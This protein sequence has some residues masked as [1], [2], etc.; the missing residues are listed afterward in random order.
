MEAF[1]LKVMRNYGGA[2]NRNGESKVPC[3]EINLTALWRVMCI[4]QMSS[5]SSH[6][7]T[8]A[9]TDRVML[10]ME[11]NEGSESLDAAK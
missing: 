1:I 2:L 5:Q 4:T 8:R 7:W 9:W 10:K 11:S 3:Q 6:I